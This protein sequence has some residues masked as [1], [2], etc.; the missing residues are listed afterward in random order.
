MNNKDVAAAHA[1]SPAQKRRIR[2]SRRRR[3]RGRQPRCRRRGRVDACAL[4]CANH[5]DMSQTPCRAAT[6][7]RPVAG[8][9]LARID[10]THARDS[11]PERNSRKRS[12]CA[13]ERCKL[14]AATAGPGAYQRRILAAR[15]RRALD[16]IEVETRAT[17][18]RSLS[19][20]VRRVRVLVEWRRTASLPSMAPRPRKIVNG[21][22]DGSKVAVDQR[23]D[24]ILRRSLSGFRPRGGGP[25]SRA[26]VAIGLRA[27]AK[28]SCGAPSRRRRK[29]GSFQGRESRV[30]G[31]LQSSDSLGS[32][33]IGGALIDCSLALVACG[34]YVDGVAK[35][36]DEAN[37]RV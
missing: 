22:A 12:P 25:G 35:V 14:R 23:D 13:R 26:G 32:V 17:P 20:R 2:R 9:A 15:R 33:R 11:R 8:A 21:R 5:A 1:A 7:H 36:R 24:R 19:C 31:V 6:E 34:L 18:L 29:R 37:D 4:E 16:A 3:P 28:R 30:D 27:A 10:R